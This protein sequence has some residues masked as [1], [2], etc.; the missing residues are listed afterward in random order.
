MLN[1]PNCL[2]KGKYLFAILIVGVCLSAYPQAGKLFTVDLEL[3]NSLIY[4]VFQDSK[5]IIWVATEDGLNRY[6]GSKFTTYKHDSRDSTSLLNNYVRLLFEDQQGNLLIGFYNGL[7]LYDRATETFRK[8][9]LVVNEGEHFDAHVITITQRQGGQ[10]LVG[11]SGYGVFALSFEGAVPSAFPLEDKI[12]ASVINLLF[13]D[14]DRNLWVFSEDKGLFRIGKQG[15]IE[16]YAAAK[17]IPPT[18]I[19]GLCQDQE[20]NLY[21]SSIK[22]GL[23]VYHSSANRFTPILYPPAPNLPISSMHLGKGDELYLGTDGYGVKIYDLKKKVITEGSFNVT[24]FDFEKSKIHAILE[25]RAGNLWLGIYQKGVMLLPARAGNFKYVGYKSVQQN[26]I[27]SNA[28]LAILED[29]EGTRWIGTD[30]DGLYATGPNGAQKAHFS[31]S[32]D[33]AS[34]PATIIS[35]YEDSD[36]NLWVGSYLKG[37]A[38][39]NPKTGKCE[40]VNT[41]LDQ[42]G[43]KVERVYGL[44]ED[45]NKNLWIGTMGAGLYS[46]DLATQRVTHYSPVSPSAQSSDVNMLHNGWINCLLVT[47]RDKLYIGTYD[48]LGCL[49]LKTKNFASTHGTNRLLRG[50]IIYSL[51]EDHSGNLWIGTSKGLIYLNPQT[52]EIKTYTTEDGLP[53]N[54]VCAIKEDK[55]HNLW[56]STHYGIS[57]LNPT[58]KRFINYFANDGLQGNEF[59]KGAAFVNKE[60]QLIFGGINGITYFSPEEIPEVISSPLPG[61]EVRITGFYLHNK[62]VKKGM[63]SGSYPI[64]D[65]AVMDAEHFHLSHQD[66]SFSLELSAMEFTHPERITYQY[67]L[68]EG[69]WISLRPGNNTVT[70]NGLAPGTYRFAFRA[71]DYNTYSNPREIS[72]LI[73]PAWYFSDWAKGGYALALGLLSLLVVLQL[74]HRYRTRQKMQQHQQAKQINEAKLQFFINIAHE[75]RT[76]MTLIINPLKRLMSI[77]DNVERQ[78]SYTTMQR[79]SQRILH[80]INQLMDIQKIDKGQAQLRFQETELVGYLKGL[81]AIFNEQSRSKHIALNFYPQQEELPLWID[82]GHFDKVVLNVLSNAFKFTPEGGKIEMYLNSGVEEHA[83]NR[84]K[85]YAELVISDSGIGLAGHELERIFECFYQ[86]KATQ[87]HFAEGTGIGLHLTRSIVTLHHGSI[88][89]ENNPGERGCRFIMRFPLGKEHLQAADTVDT[90]PQQPQTKPSA[91]ALPLPAENTPEAK[92]KP[93]TKSRILVVDDDAE[94]RRYLCQ[95][96]AAHY[97]MSECSNGKEALAMVLQQAP[98]LIISDVMMPEMDGITF[99]RKVKQHPNINHVPVVLLTAKSGDEYT[100]EGLETGADAYLVKPFHLDILQK[101]IQNLI[102]NRTLLRNNFSGSQQQQDKVQPIMLKSADEKLMKKV[103]DLINQHMSNTDLS[104]EM[105]AGEVGI[106]R[107]HLHRKMKELTNQT[108]RDFIRNTRL[109]QA[110]S[111]LTGKNQNISEVA[112]AVGF[113]SLATFSTAFKEFYGVPPT[114]YMENHSKAELVS[115]EG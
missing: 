70:F 114:D 113:T 53:S 9:P 8:I 95:E 76:P 111:L 65:T 25:D 29:Q 34:V 22:H 106:S 101:S 54:V 115:T 86:A 37:L 99:C 6:D 43:N 49:D 26:S 33:P 107:V 28:V 36:R 58:S 39:L 17:G 59:S 71:K 109:Q 50:H 85:Q 63:K 51:H 112:F 5:G 19:T 81:C 10:I 20:G 91:G 82:P 104:V 15:R 47:R 1:I 38:R 13:E 94:I 97:H 27:G 30:S 32:A 31:P 73:S 80:L 23:F 96:L 69:E 41:L 57:K 100:L 103:M 16:Y 46:M 108:T 75:I 110:A 84:P 40:Y 35:L 62:A 93:K 21:A 67:S 87:N 105:I 72:I 56:I 90:L 2:L 102:Q 12:P 78:Q 92:V 60:G 66:N 45:R 24:S 14:R 7:Q 98:D 44:A 77:D 3:S 48:G 74:R 88:R 89:A 83:E 61:L 42:N 11:T 64:V 79:N 68:Q 55:S 4:D 18:A 52:D